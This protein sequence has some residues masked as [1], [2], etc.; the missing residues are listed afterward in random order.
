MDTANVSYPQA[1]FML[2]DC[3]AMASWLDPYEEGWCNK[4]RARYDQV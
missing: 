2:Q 3:S 1:H 4:F